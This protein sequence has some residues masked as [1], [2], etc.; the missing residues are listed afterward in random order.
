M[1][2]REV[3]HLN[4]QGMMRSIECLI[5]TLMQM[6]TPPY[7][8]KQLYARNF[9]LFNGWFKI[10]RQKKQNTDYDINHIQ[11]ERILL[12]YCQSKTIQSAF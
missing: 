5:Q 12:D 1:N 11:N 3:K 2:L 9:D 10:T 7:Q 6:E 8:K 4:L